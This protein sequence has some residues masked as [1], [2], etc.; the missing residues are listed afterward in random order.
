[1][2]TEIPKFCPNCG[3]SLPEGPYGAQPYTY[4]GESGEGAIEGWDCCC[5]ECGWSGDIEP[6][7]PCVKQSLEE[8]KT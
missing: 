8:V 2:R 3:E 7:L 1:M 6:D 5:S 4:P